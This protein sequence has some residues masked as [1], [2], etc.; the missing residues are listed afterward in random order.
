MGTI[1]HRFVPVF[2]ACVLTPALSV[3]QCLQRCDQEYQPRRRRTLAHTAS[4]CQPVRVR[5]RSVGD[6]Q[7]SRLNI[8]T[9]AAAWSWFSPSHVY[10]RHPRLFLF[11]LGFLLCNLLCKLMLA[12][13]CR[14]RFKYLRSVLTPLALI[15]CL[16]L[17]TRAAASM[18]LIINSICLMRACSA[19][20][21]TLLY[22]IAAIHFAFW[23]HWSSTSFWKS[24][25]C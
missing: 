12:H 2:V 24:R 15:V 19:A 1:P 13:L 25:K 7:S 10:N 6:R 8:I 23:L 16:V 22:L 20:E 17:S 21:D 18:L 3:L 4:V 11:M 14:Y 5:T 9:C